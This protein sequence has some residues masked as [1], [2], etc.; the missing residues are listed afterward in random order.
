MLTARET[1]IAQAK[2]RESGNRARRWAAPDPN[3]RRHGLDLVARSRKTPATAVIAG[4]D[5]EMRMA[6]REAMLAAEEAAAHARTL[7]D[8]L[9]DVLAALTNAEPGFASAPVAHANAEPE[10]AP[11]SPREFEVWALVAE[12]RSNKAIAAALFISPNT[13]KTHV[14]SLLAKLDA[15]TR[16]QLAAMAARREAASFR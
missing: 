6:L 2:Q 3:V 5:P 1:M 12:G 8:R 15:D 4:I 13:V 11:L 10:A 14:A 9:E 16:A 7:A